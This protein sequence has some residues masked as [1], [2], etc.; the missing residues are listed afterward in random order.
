[1]Y[2]ECPISNGK[3]CYDFNIH[4][5]DFLLS[6]YIIIVT[7]L[8]IV[9]TRQSIFNFDYLHLAS[10]WSITVTYQNKVFFNKVFR[11]PQIKHAKNGRM[12]KTMTPLMLQVL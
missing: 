6:S 1:M 7:Y 8:I 2:G 4:G 9:M 5:N 11:V 10:H 3:I 12:S